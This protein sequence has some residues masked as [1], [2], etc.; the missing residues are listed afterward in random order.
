MQ[1]YNRLLET[2]KELNAAG[3][4]K[5]RDSYK[6]PVINVEELTEEDSP[7]DSESPS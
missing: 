7:E 2:E 1:L 6:F 4:L 3:K 5:S